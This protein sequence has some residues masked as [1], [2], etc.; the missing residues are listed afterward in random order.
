[1]VY[2]FQTDSRNLNTFASNESTLRAGEH[3]FVVWTVE[4]WRTNDRFVESLA[5]V[6]YLV[7]QALLLTQKSGS[8]VLW[9]NFSKWTNMDSILFKRKRVRYLHVKVCFWT[10]ETRQARVVC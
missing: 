1:M 4:S 3:C 8:A 6:A 5:F 7:T 2:M 10:I 9:T